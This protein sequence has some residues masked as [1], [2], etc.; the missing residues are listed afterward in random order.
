MLKPKSP[1]TRRS[2]AP[3][4]RRDTPGKILDAAER[5]FAA[6]GI[7][8]VSVR[9]ILAEAGINPALAN[10][11]FGGR[12]G[13]IQEILRV[14]LQPLDD[15][16]HRL[17]DEVEARGAGATLEDVLRA[18]HRPLFRWIFERPVT[19]QL[20]MR[21]ATSADPKVRLIHRNQ[22][23][24]V[25]ERFAQA[26]LGRAPRL[27]PIQQV[28]RFYFVQGVGFATAFAWNE[29]QT[30]ARKHF[31]SGAVPDVDGIV[32]EIVSFCAA[33]LRAPPALTRRARHG[34]SNARRHP[35]DHGHR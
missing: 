34:R 17:L 28:A 9:A 16:R 2:I 31:G 19:A 21:V 27:E 3:R 32:A 20:M 26:L 14:R 15:E 7:D 10:Y 35:A 29:L 4:P 30:S 23:R 1:S 11:H 8:G 33:G 6:R 12:D 5:L 24:P 13:L 18:F 25:L 22:Q